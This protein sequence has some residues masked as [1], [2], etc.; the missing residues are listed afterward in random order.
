MSTLRPHDPVLARF[1]TAL[2]NAY[3]SSL[4]RVVLYGSRA[5]SEARSDSD[6]DVA[7]FLRGMADRAAEMNRLAGI[8]TDI[9]HES[10]ECIYAMPFSAGAYNE[11]RPSTSTGRGR[12]KL[13]TRILKLA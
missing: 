9:L 12:D 11:E 13:R 7:V 3:G 1:R 2:A 8:S 10:G 5:R 6:Y 4:E